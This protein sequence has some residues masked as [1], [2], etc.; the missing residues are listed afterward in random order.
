MMT[1]AVSATHTLRLPPEHA[2]LRWHWL[3]G[4]TG[5]PFVAQWEASTIASGWRT[6]AG[7][8]G[9][10]AMAGGGIRY[11]GPCDPAAVVVDAR[12][13]AQRKVIARILARS[14]GLHNTVPDR[15]LDAATLVLAALGRGE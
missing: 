4:K 7:W 1:V 5:A 10:K 2:H 9:A 6:F 13:E 11:H 12:N 14:E 15:F 8:S 3:T